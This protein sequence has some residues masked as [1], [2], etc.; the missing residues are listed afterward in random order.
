[1]LLLISTVDFKIARLSFS[2]YLDETLQT[3]L[4]LVTDRKNQTLS[5]NFT[6]LVGLWTE[7]LGASYFSGTMDDLV[8]GYFRLRLVLSACADYCDIN[9]FPIE[10]AVDLYRSKVATEISRLTRQKSEGG[11]EVV[12]EGTNLA[13]D[14]RSN[15]A[16]FPFP[17]ISVNADGLFE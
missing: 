4:P 5:D 6:H 14:T 12:P 3:L 16:V 13:H 11:W 17:S 15:A 1:M 10:V 2:L 8:D 7:F 9:W